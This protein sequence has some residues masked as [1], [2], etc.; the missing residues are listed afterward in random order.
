MTTQHK[1]IYVSFA[2]SDDDVP[3]D[4]LE[5]MREP[6]TP[7]V[8][9]NMRRKTRAPR[10][11][12]NWRGDLDG[13]RKPW[14]ILVGSSAIEKSWADAVV[15]IES[16]QVAA[17]IYF[18]LQSAEA[19]EEFEFERTVRE[20]ARAGE[21]PQIVRTD[22]TVE[23][24]LREVQWDDAYEAALHAGA[25]YSKVV[26]LAARAEIPALVTKARKAKVRATT[27]Q[28]KADTEI[29]Q[30]LN[31]LRAIREAD[32][33]LALTGKGW[34]RTTA[35]QAAIPGKAL[36]GLG[37]IAQLLGSTNPMVDGTYVLDTSDPLPLH[38]RA[39]INAEGGENG[40]RLLLAV[41]GFEGW[42]IS[43]YTIEHKNLY[44]RDIEFEAAL[45]R[46]SFAQ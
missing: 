5:A 22:W 42:A 40:F 13:A 39:A 44:V 7:W 27:A 16:A 43:Q 35:D 6:T 21:R 38:T 30:Y 11:Q 25:N 46:R 23:R 29:R 2:R 19:A 4:N 10:L 41:E 12:T 3:F 45:S 18:G 32:A 36:N 24:I 20:A 33:D 8:P 9:P 17:D 37:A 15:A 14:H 26:A 28:V 34:H 31:A 1:E